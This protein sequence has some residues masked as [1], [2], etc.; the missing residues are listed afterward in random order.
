MKKVWIGLGIVVFLALIG[1]YA[2]FKKTDETYKG[3]SIIPE[4]HKD[5]PLFQG[6][7][8]TRHQYV[9]KGNHW[10]AIHDYYLEKLPSLGWS[11]K[12]EAAATSNIPAGGF[13]ST[14]IKEGFDGELWVWGNY[15]HFEDQTEVTFD[16]MPIYKS[17]IWIVQA[18][19]SVC[20]FSN[21]VDSK[22]N[23]FTDK[24]NVE[25]IASLINKAIDWKEERM[26]R[27]NTG[28]I[29]FGDLKV[30][31]F[32]ESDKEIYFE[33]DKGTKLMKPEK[34][35]FELTQFPR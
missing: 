16:K 33:S 27:K 4:Q 12:N 28:L 5:I 8:P 29:N 15:N 1:G 2:Y 14:W 19:E 25:A 13:Y 20:I 6:L 30:K 31:V 21:A 10:V 9:M 17:S 11:L 22:C 23:K 35:F 24:T 3:M 18:P 7:K 32:Y 26:P 34:E